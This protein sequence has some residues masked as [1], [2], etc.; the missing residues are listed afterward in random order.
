MWATRSGRVPVTIALAALTIGT[1]T[2]CSS[3]DGAPPYEA[4]A[5]ARDDDGRT[6]ARVWDEATLALIREV[7]PAPTEHARNLFH[8]S[9]AMWDAWAAYDPI[10]DGYFVTDKIDADDVDDVTAAREAAISY[11]AYRILLWRYG[12]VSD[13]AAAQDRLDATMAGLCYR[14]DYTSVDGDSPA[15]L[16]NRI[17]AEVIEATSDDGSL[18]AERYIDTSYV[19]VNDPLV[20]DEPGTEMRDPNRWQPL[21]LGTQIAQNGLPI[22]GK[23]QTYVGP[24]WGHVTPFALDPSQAGLP[25]DPG[26]PPQLGDPDTDAAFKD[27]ALEVIRDSAKL[28][29]TDGVTI[30]IGPGAMGDNSLGTNGG[31]GHDV[32]AVTGEPYEVNRVPEGDFY[33]VIAEYWADGPESETPP[34]HWNLLANALQDAPG[35]ERRLGGEGPLLDDLEWDVKVYFALNGA[36][37]DA[38]VAGWG[39]KGYYD[40]VRP[41]SM[42][43]YMGGKGQSSDPDGPSYDPEGLPL[44]PGLVEVVTDASSATG[45]RHEELADHIG[46]VAIRAWRGNPD[47]PEIE[48][49][50]VGWIR[51][52]EWVPYQRPTFVTPAFAGYVSGHSTF[53]RA[54]AEILTAATGSPA[55]PGGLAE[56]TV[57]RGTLR[58]EEGPSEDVTLQ[59]A[60][61]YDAADQAGISRLYGGIH[62]PADD[63]RGR[64]MGAECGRH[65]WELA[66]QYFAGSIDPRD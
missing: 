22:P 51:A 46:E 38:A 45:E 65:A 61:Y 60:T 23:V 39:S 35:F 18:E 16:G 20:V 36:L 4:A 40:S 55:F 14:P 43:R 8:V 54:G 33:R 28:D 29:P 6:V 66:E 57:E 10:A 7:I 15:D 59:W 21:S 19:A 63:V 1:V 52:V 24:H 25:I 56:W 47:D 13:L 37:H 5:C 12:T 17:A 9:A 30:D 62:I 41:I 42:I 34:G 48:T 53:S 27:A 64:L 58:H 32:N 50:G 26:T 44:E 3:D 11:A 49:S 2:A 31:D